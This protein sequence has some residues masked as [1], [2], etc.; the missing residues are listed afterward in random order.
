MHRQAPRPDA[1]DPQ[2]QPGFM[3]R[4]W[5]GGNR[6]GTRWRGKLPI[7]TRAMPL[8]RRLFEIM[9]AEKTVMAEVAARAGMRYSTISDWRH[10]RSPLLREF[11]AAVNALGYEL[12]IRE[13]RE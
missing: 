8:V 4:H 3:K 12:V 1:T 5:R 10:R 9:N 7:P 13:R 11:E 2:Q 6:H